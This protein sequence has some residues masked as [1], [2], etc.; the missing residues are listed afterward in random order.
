MAADSSR[1]ARSRTAFALACAALALLGLA[2]VTAPAGTA[3]RAS[4]APVAG[5]EPPARRQVFRGDD[6]HPAFDAAAEQA[7]FEG[8]A[9]AQSVIGADERVRLTNTNEYPLRAIAFLGMYDQSGEFVGHCTGTFI[10]PNA[11]LTAAHC[12]WDPETGWTW[13]IRVVPGRNG[14]SEPYGDAWAKDWWVPDGWIDSEGGSEWDWGIIKMPSSTLG[15]TVGWFSIGVVRSATLQQPDFEPAIIG[16]SGDK[17]LGTLWGAYKA[18]FLGVTDTTLIHD[19]DTYAGESG[20][21]VF[22]LNSSKYYFGYIVG[23]HVRGGTTANEASR[24]DMFLLND[25]LD[26]C[27]A[28]GCQV[29]WESEATTGPTPTPTRTATPTPTRTATATATPTRTPPPPVTQGPRGD[30]RLRMPILASDR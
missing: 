3:A 18:A 29:D 12:L 24:I 4:D 30:Y 9:S 22:S 27:T 19:V 20:S 15:T 6:R 8:H 16:Y 11:L 21:A 26:A 25:L 1:R 10:S 5:E 28:M 14:S 23:I 2:A 17:P 7:W 13:D